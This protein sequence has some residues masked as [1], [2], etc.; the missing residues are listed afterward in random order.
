MY[1]LSGSFIVNS[2]MYDGLNTIVVS[3]NTG[4]SS[5]SYT[6]TYQP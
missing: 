2:P 4:A 6:F 1:T 5:G 3:F